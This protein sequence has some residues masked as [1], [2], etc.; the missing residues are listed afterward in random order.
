MK[1][2]SEDRARLEELLPQFEAVLAY[3][4]RNTCLHDETY[5]G[6]TIWEI[7]DSCGAKWADNEG[8]KPADVHDFPKVL[9]DARDLLYKI[10]HQITQEEIRTNLS[11]DKTVVDFTAVKAALDF[12]LKA[13]LTNSGSDIANA[14]VDGATGRVP[15]W[16][17]K[18]ISLQGEI[19]DPEW[20][21]YQR[22]KR[23]FKMP[24]SQFWET[25]PTIRD[26][27]YIPDAQ[28]IAEMEDNKKTKRVE[29]ECPLN[30]WETLRDAINKGE[31]E[32]EEVGF[33]PY[34]FACAELTDKKQVAIAHGKNW[35]IVPWATIDSLY[36]VRPRKNE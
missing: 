30:G 13:P 21:E 12:Y 9:T 26:E 4:E 18:L 32:A 8:G 27:H 6:G 33:L 19:E 14:F 3:A 15:P 22:L 20:K 1:F 25:V 36:A 17:R 11:V 28:E 34:G 31:L 7:C 5:R 23:K 10:A 29:V 24:E 2:K 16:L 35:M